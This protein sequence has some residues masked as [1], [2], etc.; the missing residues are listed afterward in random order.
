LIL[1][2][3]LS[4]SALSAPD[5]AELD[6]IAS[7]HFPANEPGAAVLVM[8]D[9]ETL[10]RK[11]YG[12]ADL[13][14]AIAIEPDM[15]FRIGSVTKQFTAAAIL[16]L[17]EAGK[18]SV[19][20]DLRKY[21]PDY[22]TH[23]RVITIEHLL[24]HTSGIRSYTDMASFGENIRKDMTIDEV[25]ALFKDE[26]LTFEPGEKY[27]YN[28]SGY[29]LLGAI[30][31]KASGKSYESFLQEKIFEP[32][33]MTQTYYGSAARIIPK[34]A[35][36]YDGANGEFQNA[37]YLSMTLPYAAGSLLS[38]VDDLAKWD[39]AL[40]KPGLLSRQS[41]EKWWKPFH[42]ANGESIH[43]GYGWGISEYEGHRVV[44]HGG[45]IN[46][47]TCHFLR[48]P[49][50]GIV[51]AVL[52]NRN[53]EKT[54]PGLVARKLA[55]AAAG[56]PVTEKTT[57]LRPESLAKRPGLYRTSADVRYLVTL[58]GGHLLLRRY[59]DEHPDGGRTRNPGPNEGLNRRARKLLPVS[60]AQFLIE[61]SLTSVVFEGPNRLIVED[62]G[63]VERAERS[64]EPSDDR[65][66]VLS[67]VET[68]LAGITAKDK[69]TMLSVLDR[70]ARFV[71]A[72]TRNGAPRL[73]P[74]TAAEFVDR[75]LEHDGPPLRQE[76]RDP[77]V[78]LASGLATVWAP[79][80]F[81]AG[82]RLIHCGE[83][84]F[85]L[86]KTDVVWPG[87]KIV[88]VADTVETEGCKPN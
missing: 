8:K 12:L 47:F 54:N 10:L 82:D 55:A 70:D 60:E 20:E 39:R 32:L 58:D 86:A 2:S 33:G 15:V 63:R 6:A 40:Q 69:G 62:W 76:I 83:D 5:A 16:L 13:E 80:S 52:T 31:E 35:Q 85:Q 72:E 38:T 48:M 41:L 74:M 64:S 65:S 42:L 36:G 67:A 59:G 9:G 1:V 79:Y 71:R 23:G 75:I 11:G 51:V 68:L 30:I 27:A 45:G 21:L 14:Q 49:D 81:Y 53:D 24:T 43:Y 84:A 19:Q 87:W 77:E 28:N 88:A 25:I 46:G 7:S 29:F 18:L 44:S 66:R 73:R 57:V 37:E 50:D 61:E 17:E 4:K 56:K 34:R 78:R 26:P 3:L 22:P